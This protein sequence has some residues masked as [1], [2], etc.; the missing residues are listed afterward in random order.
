MYRI[1]EIRKSNYG[2]PKSIME[3]HKS[4]KKLHQS[5]MEL[6]KY[7]ELSSSVLE[8]WSSIIE[9]W[10]SIIRIMDL[11]NSLLEYIIAETYGA[12]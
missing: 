4:N 6:H 3:L 5:I 12:P 11:H 10:S 7:V 8:L 2:A 1:M 9:L